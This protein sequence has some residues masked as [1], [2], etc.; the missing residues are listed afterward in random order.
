[1]NLGPTALKAST[2]PLGYPGG[3][4]YACSW[5]MFVVFFDIL[6]VFSGD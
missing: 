3:M 1:M 6:R 2:L 5:S 4:C